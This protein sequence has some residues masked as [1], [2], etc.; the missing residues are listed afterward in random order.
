MPFY[1]D[2]FFGDLVVLKMSDEQVV[3][4]LRLLWH[5]WGFGALPN[6]Q[7]ALK[8]L[9]GWSAEESCHETWDE[10]WSALAPCF[11][12]CGEGLANPRCLLE[13]QKKVKVA[14]KRRASG[15]KGAAS[16][17]Q[18]PSVCYGNTDGNTNG[19]ACGCSSSS[20]SSSDVRKEQPPCREPE[21][22]DLE[23]ASIEVRDHYLEKV[24]RRDQTRTTALDSIV[25]LLSGE[26]PPDHL[27][28]A[29]TRYAMEIPE[30][31][32]PMGCRTFYAMGHWERFLAPSWAP[33][34]V[35][36]GSEPS[37][38]WDAERGLFVDSE[39]RP[40]VE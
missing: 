38:R 19:K 7:K 34:R 37:I 1:G 14:E 31:G 39:G 36:R 3:A 18:L 28:L 16:R 23:K 12:Q 20:S 10:F 24:N 4:Y 29:A 32:K 30:D 9:T 33:P 25:V 35:P 5:Q 2:D 13:Q 11:P 26:I 27:K 15:Q 22:I 21:E 8:K 17:W 6:D 40:H